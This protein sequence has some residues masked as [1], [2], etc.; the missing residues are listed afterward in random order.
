MTLTA[1]MLL[2]VRTV[3]EAPDKG[4]AS[5]PTVGAFALGAILL[6]PFVAIELR[7]AAPLVRLG[8]LRSGRSCARTSA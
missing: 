1:A 2:L 5:A 7:A 8:I 6:A 4:W 3:V